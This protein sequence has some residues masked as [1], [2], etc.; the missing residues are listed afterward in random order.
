[1]IYDHKTNERVLTLEA[2]RRLGDVWTVNLDALF[3]HSKSPPSLQDLASGS[4]DP[5]Y[6][7]AQNGHNDLIQLEV[8]RYF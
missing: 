8:V 3:F 2:S 4:F 6:K 7:L 5:L 1:M